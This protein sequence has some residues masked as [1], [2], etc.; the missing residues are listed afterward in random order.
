[1]IEKFVIKLE[2]LFDLLRSI[3]FYKKTHSGVLAV[4]GLNVSLPFKVWSSQLFF[5]KFIPHEHYHIQGGEL[6]CKFLPRILM[7]N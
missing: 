1:M 6:S 2:L 4:Q 3:K 5:E 7:R